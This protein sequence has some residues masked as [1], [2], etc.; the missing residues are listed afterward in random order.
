MQKAT[1]DAIRMNYTATQIIE[2]LRAKDE[3]VLRHLYRQ[4]SPMI[5]G[6]VRKNSGSDE[7]AREMIQI[8]MLQL[9]TAVQEGR[10]TE[11]GK[12][13]RYIFQLAANNWRYELRRR[14][15]RPAGTLDDAMTDFEDESASHLEAAIVKDRYLNAVH[16][17][18]QKLDSPC[19]EII[20]LYHLQE[21]SLQEVSKR[22]NYDYDNLRKRIFDCRKKLK[23]ITESILGEL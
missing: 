19:D 7:D 11:E 1:Y 5:A 14:R 2:G 12:L 17:A 16:Q 3:A 6:H 21:V 9:W 20:R 10:Y 15:N 18:L 22:M 4:H 8:T 23:K 13:D